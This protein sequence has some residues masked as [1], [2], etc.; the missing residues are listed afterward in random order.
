MSIDRMLLLTYD[1]DHDSCEVRML[2]DEGLAEMAKVLE[3]PD[4]R[5]S[6]TVPVTDLV[7]VLERWAAV[8]R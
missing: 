4:G 3:E 8:L 7:D 1:R 5:V 2:T 6:V